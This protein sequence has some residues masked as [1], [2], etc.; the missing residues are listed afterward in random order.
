LRVAQPLEPRPRALQLAFADLLCKR[1]KRRDRRDDVARRLPGPESL[2]L[3]EHDLLGTA[4]L[5]PPPREAL[6]HDALQ[7]VDVVQVAAVE[8][9]DRRI[10]VTRNR[11]VD[12]EQ[13]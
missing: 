7:V 13:R 10:E 4:G 8:L 3:L 12:E 6:R 11:D 2:R 9:V 1:A 5:A